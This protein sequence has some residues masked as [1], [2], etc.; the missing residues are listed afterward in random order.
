M[1]K[2]AKDASGTYRL[3]AMDI[4]EVS[5]VDRAANRRRF[6]F[7]KREG[8]M[9]AEVKDRG[10]GT[11]ELVADQQQAEVQKYDLAPTHKEA[12]EPSLHKLADQVLAML[13]SVEA[14][15]EAAEGTQVP[16]EVGDGL[17]AI[18][19]M[20]KEIR[21]TLQLAAKPMGDEKKP[22]EDAVPEVYPEPE[23]AKQEAQK[24]QP[25][26][27]GKV[28]V[29]PKCGYE[30]KGDAG[31]Q[32]TGETCPKCGAKMVRK[33]EGSADVGKASVHGQLA[34]ELLDALG[35][36]A[37]DIKD[38]A[39]SWDSRQLDEKLDAMYDLGS[40]LRRALRATT[41]IG[42]ADVDAL[43]AG[44][45]GAVEKIGRKMSGGNLSRFEGSLGVIAGEL[46]KLRDLHVSL[47]PQDKREEA[48]KVWK[49]V[50][51]DFGFDR[52]PRKPDNAGAGTRPLNTAQ[53]MEA[54]G[55]GAMQAPMAA[56]AKAEPD[57]GREVQPPSGGKPEAMV[58]KQG[59]RDPGWPMDM[60]ASS[61][62]AAVR[63]TGRY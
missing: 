39:A 61:Y 5:L 42:K 19:G 35:K 63:R 25:G 46:D 49:R 15:K 2:L 3:T 62:V 24:A 40:Q 20:V 8:I 1:K 11:L 27:V 14:S 55:A 26:S 41:L 52:A 59:P 12:L 33:E 21:G 13:N 51:E 60:N 7:A 23:A 31:A 47:L 34:A 30:M 58:E 50:I 36:A 43:L 28:C 32:C 10:D 17:E 37:A 57:P 16:P 54:S 53:G 9:T 6:L 48:S 45:V 38:N 29:C 44:D 22:E 18:D 56:V 4:K